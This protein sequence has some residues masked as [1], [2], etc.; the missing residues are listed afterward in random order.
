MKLA[1]AALLLV[2][3]G[4][5]G[6]CV[7]PAPAGVATAAG[8]AG[9]DASSPTMSSPAEYAERPISAEAGADY[10]LRTGGGD[11]Y[12]A[13]L[14]Y[15]IFLALMDAYPEELG[16]DWN[17]FSEKFG[18]IPDPAQKGNPRSPPIGFHLTVDPNTNVPW[19]VG[20]RPLRPCGPVAEP[21]GAGDPARGAPACVHRR[22]GRPL[23]PR[24]GGRAL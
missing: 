13:G 23:R 15:P 4:L 22:H 3:A 21:G 14:A 20:A 10:F 24:P 16:K 7:R 5:L 2:G 1:L 11:P 18:L 17:E 12:A 19:V 8:A 9:D 6:A